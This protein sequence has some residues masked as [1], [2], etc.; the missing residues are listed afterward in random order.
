MAGHNTQSIGAIE[1]FWRFLKD[2]KTDG[3]RGAESATYIPAIPLKSYIRNNIKHLLLAV[4]RPGADLSRARDIATSY[5]LVFAI[6]ISIDE[7][8]FIYD[9]ARH[10][11]LN[12][13][14]LPFED[15]K[16][17]PNRKDFFQ[18]FHKK[19]WEFCAPPLDYLFERT[20]C[21]HWILPFKREADFVAKG[22]TGLVYK[23]KI[24]EEYDSLSPVSEPIQ[25]EME[26]V[27]VFPSLTFSRIPV[28]HNQLFECSN[29]SQFPQSLKKKNR[30]SACYL[31]TE[32]RSISSNTSAATSRAQY[33]A[34]F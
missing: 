17:F 20:F 19:Q 32:N 28:L 13:H 23:I 34:S 16:F 27:M 9:F 30:P 10:Q 8:G 5:P 21:E 25:V 31:N 1:D 14:R 2:H 4:S 33:G 29:C 18:V 15:S 7:G 11:E 22:N 3:T 12:D 6:L 24:L 26:F